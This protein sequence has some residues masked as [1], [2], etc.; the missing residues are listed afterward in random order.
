MVSCQD[1]FPWRLF[2]ALL[3]DDLK[4]SAREQV[5][6]MLM[7]DEDTPFITADEEVKSE[8]R[9]CLCKIFSSFE[10]EL[11]SLLEADLSSETAE[12]KALPSLSDLDWMCNI[13]PKMDLMK[14]FVSSWVEI[15][16]NIL[17]VIQDKKFDSTLWGV[18]VKLIE[19]VG[20]VLDAVG[21]GNVILPTPARVHLLKIWLPYIRRMKPLLDLQGSEEMGFPY[22]M[23]EDLC[24]NIEAA[25]VSLV[26]ALP[27]ND[28]ADI[29]VDW[30][31]TEQVRYPD[32][33]EAFEVW[34]YR[35]K[36][37]K[38]RLV[39]GLNGIDNGTVSL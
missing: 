30:M 7:E 17:A 23:D 32:L 31:Q 9:T 28:Q 21:F 4:V 37:A 33:S 2:I 14:D 18:K 25:I 12:V 27:S 15:S 22:K 16:C 35:T 39:V 19:V 34:C 20:K 29:L 6:Y 26:L 38:R 11:G 8:I 3:T 36:A 24:Q 13:L 10:K 5:E 1:P